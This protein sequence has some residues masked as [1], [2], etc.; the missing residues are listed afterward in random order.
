MLP[1]PLAA[2][3]AGAS[4]E[5]I[6][7]SLDD[8]SFEKIESE[9]PL[10]SPQ[11][12]EPVE[13]GSS[14]ARRSPRN[15]VGFQ[16]PKVSFE[17]FASQIRLE[18]YH[19]NRLHFLQ[20]RHTSIQTAIALSA[21]LHRI[22]TSIQDGLVDIS[23]RDDKAGFVHV[24]H[25]IGELKDTFYN[26]W[27]RHVHLSDSVVQQA[28]HGRANDPVTMCFYSRLSERSRAELF[29][30]IQRLRKNPGFLVERFKL[31]SQSQISAL[32]TRPYY[33][34]IH[35]SGHSS[36]SRA[37]DQNK[38]NTTYSNTLK[39]FAL[40]FERSDPISLLLFNVYGVSADPDSAE[41]M[42]RLDTWSSVCAQLFE[43][44]E[45]EYRPLINEILNTFASLHEWRAKQRL[46]LFL[47]DQLQASAFLLQV[48]NESLNVQD[49][50]G[51]FLDPLSTQDATRF[52][53]DAV[54]K[55]FEILDDQDGGLPYGALH[56]GS[57]V[58]GKLDQA[59]QMTFRGYLLHTW[60]FSEFLRTTMTYPEVG[61][62]EGAST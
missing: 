56:F 21:R 12:P 2:P 14:E 42:L 26:H 49:L 48:S 8:F 38:A 20:Q 13:E 57:A 52:F 15:D 61:L 1:V 7:L 18:G 35:T 34:P 9:Q 25:T 46:E 10:Q 23:R 3:A 4:V 37:R 24:Y 31:L 17:A 41:R 16:R 53:D 40:A 5:D 28:N 54:H 62:A 50:G 36:S 47:M 33:Q 29:E 6:T 30:L 60:F 43:A 32:R 59:H 19:Q 45:T 51:G 39:D 55:L 11:T 22:G 58:L 44:S 27:K